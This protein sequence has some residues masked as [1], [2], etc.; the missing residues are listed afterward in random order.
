MPARTSGS[1]LITGGAGYIGSHVVWALADR[2]ADPVVIDN[3]STG[4]R[5]ALPAGVT[6]HEAD[7][8]DR[9]AV[10]RVLERHRPAAV[11][12]FAGSVVVPESVAD[13]LKYYGNN[14]AASL[15]LLAECTAAG[16][17]TFIF[18]S[19]AAVY[20]TPDHI[21]VTEEAPTRPL[22][23]YGWSKLMFEQ[24]LRDTALVSGMKVG[25]LRYFNVA[26]AD[27]DLRTGQ[28]S[29]TATHLI[30][31]ACQAALGRRPHLTIFGDDYETPDGTG[32]RDFIH[33]SDLAAAHLSALD[34]LL[35]GG[36]SFTLNCGYGRGYSVREVVAKLEAVLGARLPVV[37]AARRPGDAG[38]VV[39]DSSR[40]RRTLPWTPRHDDLGTIVGHALAWERARPS[41]TAT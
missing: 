27:P 40:L 36:E 7:I 12:H 33:V 20:G 28:F 4:Y 41:R 23:P 18:S 25:I 14:V 5:A 2:G 24:M 15:A 1:I 31:V 16:V 34:H 6:L 21:P 17:G 26:G 29:P 22:N 10:R 30:T 38:A 9:A 37:V 13:P 35:G 19:T 3:F 11:I 8:G 39:A 32:V